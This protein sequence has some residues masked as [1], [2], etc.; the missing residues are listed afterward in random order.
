MTKIRSI[1]TGYYLI[2]IHH[3]PI[4]SNKPYLLRVYNYDSDIVEMRTTQ[5][6]ID[7]F[8]NDLELSNAD[9]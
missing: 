3:N 6:E 1:D 4:L 2:E 5:N 8:L 9:S 7:N